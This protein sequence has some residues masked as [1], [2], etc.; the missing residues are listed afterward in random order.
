MAVKA[1]DEGSLPRRAKKLGGFEA[2]GGNCERNAGPEK[3][4]SA[5][6]PSIKG[7][8]CSADFIR[9]NVVGLAVNAE[10]QLERNRGERAG[11]AHEAEKW[12]WNEMPKPE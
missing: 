3:A 1:P 12:R 6:A 8:Q 4:E 7:N 11:K 10:K 9:T 5:A 2:R